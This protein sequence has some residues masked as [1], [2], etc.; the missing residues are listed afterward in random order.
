MLI[1]PLFNVHADMGTLFGLKAFAVA[2]LGGIRQRLGRDARGPA[3][4]RRRGA[5]HRARSARATPRSSRFAL[6]IVAL[7]AAAERPVRPRRGEEGMSAAPRMLRARSP[8]LAAVSPL[9]S[10]VRRDRVNSYYVFVL[11]N[12]ALTAIVG[13]G[14]NVLLGLTGQVS[15]GHV[16]FY[17][18]GAY[19]VAILTTEP[20]WRFWLALAGRRRCSPARRRAC[21][22]CRRC[23]CGA[24][25]SRWSRSPSASSSS[26]A[27]SNGAGSPAARTAS[28]ACR[29]RAARRS[30]GGE[31]GGGAARA[32]SPPAWRSRGFAWLSR[33]T[34]GAAMRAVRDSETA[35]ESIGLDPVAIK[36]VAFAVSAAL[37]R[38]SPAALFAPLSG[39][40]TPQHVRVPAVDP[41]RAGGDDRRR[42]LGRRAAGRRGRRRCCCPSCSSGLAEYRLLFFGALL[43]VVLWV[44]PDGVVGAAAALLRAAARRARRAARRRRGD[45]AASRRA[46]RAR[47][48]GRKA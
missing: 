16:G 8:R 7:G 6:V 2:I 48:A 32:S 4:R 18:I 37:R 36:T 21:S 40:V 17:A 41:V 22:R 20:G 19:T 11:A 35:A 46:Q 44:A 42:R 34:W 31:R 47:A 3:L 12:V 15:F 24:R 29:A 28:W 33:G 23:A 27:R 9:R 5:D 13:I 26:T 43:L 45:L 39:F 38:R 25:T 1:A 30:A 10:P 14:L